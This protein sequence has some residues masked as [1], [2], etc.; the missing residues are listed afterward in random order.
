VN[1]KT[2][3]FPFA[4]AINFFSVSGLLIIAGLVGKAEL[5]A[6]IGVIQGSIFAVF[7]SLSGNAR[8]LILSKNS[9]DIEKSL[10]YFRL[11][12]LLP[13]VILAYLL[14]SSLIDVPAYLVSG[15]ILRKCSEWLVEL[16]LANREQCEDFFYAIRYSLINLLGFFMLVLGLLVSS[17]MLIFKV[18]IFIW[19]VLPILFLWPYIRF[20]TSLQKIKVSFTPLIPHLGSSSIIGIST[21]I[22]RILIVILAGKI[23]AGQVFTAYALGGVISSVY[24]YAIGPTLVLKSGVRKNNVM[25][26]MVSICIFLGGALVLAPASIWSEEFYSPFFMHG[27]GFSLMGGGIMLLAQQQR[28]YLLQVYEKDVFVPDALI[29]ILIISSIPFAYYIF[30]DWAFTVFFLW[31]AILN[32]LFYISLGIKVARV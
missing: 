27:I 7:L 11:L 25:L 24:T 22:F 16:Q 5:A 26:L 9:E 15:L 18:I 17:D 12:T 3:L 14:A 6:N 4:T 2:L 1:R 30:G 20:V 13:A 21:Y 31:S 29:N 8:N 23:L 28:L 32:F 19:A 10:V